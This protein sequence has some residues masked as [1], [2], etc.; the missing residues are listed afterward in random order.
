MTEQEYLGD[1]IKNEWNEFYLIETINIPHFG[2]DIKVNLVE[3]DEDF[4]PTEEM[5]SKQT[6]DEY[7]KTL[8]LFLADIDNI[9]L[10]IKQSTFTYY[11]EIYTKYYEKPFEVIFDN[12]KVKKNANNELHQPLQIDTKEKHFNYID[13][14]L[15]KIIISNNKT[16]VIP[17]IYYLDEEHGIEVKIRNNKVIRVG[18]LAD[19]TYE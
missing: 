3:Y 1:I 7:T 13:S 8:K 12:E 15:E 5:P 11:L 14:I 17:F 4:E 19:T 10:D 16:I 2:D 18:G 9:M 6:V